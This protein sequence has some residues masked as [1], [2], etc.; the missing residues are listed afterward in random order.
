MSNHA[1]NHRPYCLEDQPLIEQ[2]YASSRQAEMALLPWTEAEKAGFLRSQC[3]AQLAHYLA[4]YPNSH[5]DIVLLDQQPIGRLYVHRT[6]EHILLVDI[7]LLPSYRNR[8]IGSQLI[9]AL[10]AEAGHQQLPLDLQ[11]ACINPDA[12]RLY[13]RLGFTAVSQQ[14][15]HIFMTHHP[16][17]RSLAAASGHSIGLQAISPIP[18]QEVL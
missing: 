1:L 13:Q 2:I 8:G 15:I 10:M 17:N 16:H 4:Y 5:H 6:T 7:T 18:T 12:F 11:V 9:G 3:H 14:G